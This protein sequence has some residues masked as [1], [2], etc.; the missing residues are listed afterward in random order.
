MNPK[1][2]DLE[3]YY[4]LPMFAMTSCNKVTF[5]R[6]IVPKGIYACIH[7]TIKEYEIKRILIIIITAILIRLLPVAEYKLIY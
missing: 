3:N 6:T 5:I 4:G 2:V 1:E 7:L